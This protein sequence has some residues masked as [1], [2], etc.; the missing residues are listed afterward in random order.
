MLSALPA[1]LRLAFPG[2]AERGRGGGVEEDPSRGALSLG[3]Q[4]WPVPIHHLQ[5]AVDSRSV[6]RADSAQLLLMSLKQPTHPK[7]PA[8]A[9]WLGTR[10]S[11]AASGIAPAQKTFSSGQKRR[12]IGC[13]FCPSLNLSCGLLKRSAGKL[14]Y[15]H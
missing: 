9:G 2:A 3:V 11:E 1:L 4:P 15:C 6:H 13:A 5:N 12:V 8:T 7:F 10:Q 14:I